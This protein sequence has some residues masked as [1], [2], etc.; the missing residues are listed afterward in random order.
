MF[1]VFVEM[2]GFVIA[3]WFAINVVLQKTKGM[4]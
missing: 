1:N 2:Q 3:K 4:A